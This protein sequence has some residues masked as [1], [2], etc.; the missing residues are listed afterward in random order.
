MGSIIRVDQSILLRLKGKF[1]LVYINLDITKT[2]PGSITIIKGDIT[3]RVPIIYE[4]LHEVCPL[5]GGESHQLEVCPKLPA[6][7]KI[8]VF[9]EKF[10]N[11]GLSQANRTTPVDPL[12]H[13]SHSKN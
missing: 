5:C 6:P 12:S 9:V 8:E 1:A 2:L 3:V 7:P 10:D 13:P 11:Q 4:G